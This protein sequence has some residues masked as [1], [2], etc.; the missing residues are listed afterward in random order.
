[1][2]AGIRRLKAHELCCI[3]PEGKQL[4]SMPL[5]NRQV[6]SVANLSYFAN[7]LKLFGKFYSDSSIFAQLKNSTNNSNIKIGKRG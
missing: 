6:S 5:W 1:L 4:K 3:L 7:I 2:Q